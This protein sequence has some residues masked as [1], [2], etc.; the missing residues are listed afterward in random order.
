[1]YA[2]LLELRRTDPVLAAQD[3]RTMQARALTRDVLAVHRWRTSP[4]SPVRKASQGSGRSARRDGDSMQQE[5]L[6]LVNFGDQ[7]WRE[8]SFGGGWRVLVD[9]GQPTLADADGVTIAARSASVLARDN[10]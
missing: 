4:A 7:E 3:R 1:L 5:R 10:A 9:S 8:M 2:T 6:L